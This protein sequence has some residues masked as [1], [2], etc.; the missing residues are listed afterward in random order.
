LE[1][2]FGD[3]EKDVHDRADRAAAA[4]DRS[5]DVARQG[6]ACREASILPPTLSIGN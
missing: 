5:I 6:N 2:S 1:K 3:A 4:P